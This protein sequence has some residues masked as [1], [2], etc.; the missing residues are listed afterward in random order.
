MSWCTQ[1]YVACVIAVLNLDGET[2][3]GKALRLAYEI[4]RNQVAGSIGEC[5]SSNGGVEVPAE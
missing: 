3:V 2:L 1:I 5:L 4:I